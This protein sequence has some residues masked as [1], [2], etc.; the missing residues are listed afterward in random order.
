VFYKISWMGEDLLILQ[1]GL[2]SMKLVGW[3]VIWLV[4]LLVV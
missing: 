1:E 4:S 3:L 2:Y